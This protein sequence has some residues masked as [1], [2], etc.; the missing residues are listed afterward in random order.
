MPSV[1][2][3]ILNRVLTL[4]FTSV[5]I[6]WDSRDF[7]LGL[8]KRRHSE[9]RPQIIYMTGWGE[10]IPGLLRIECLEAGTFSPVFRKTP[11]WA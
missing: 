1:Q 5:S 7:Q 8:S 2:R 3:D 6:K 11:T 9:D 4:I 10:G